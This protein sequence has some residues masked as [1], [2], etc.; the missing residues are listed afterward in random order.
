MSKTHAPYA[1]IPAQSTQKIMSPHSMIRVTRE[2]E[3]QVTLGNEN[4]FKR[5][6]SQSLLSTYQ[7]HL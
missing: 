4:E 1:M 6:S 3:L 7:Y 5:R 2:V